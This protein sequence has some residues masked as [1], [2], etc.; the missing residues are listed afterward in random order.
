MNGMGE[1]KDNRLSP[2]STI[3]TDPSPKS[4]DHPESPTSPSH[5]L[6]PIPQTL[7]PKSSVVSSN[8]SNNGLRGPRSII[9]LD[10]DSMPL[11]LFPRRPFNLSGPLRR[12]SS[13]IS[14][15]ARSPHAST[16]TSTY[17]TATDTSMF[18]A[19]TAQSTFATTTSRASTEFYSVDGDDEQGRQSGEYGPFVGNG[20]NDKVGINQNDPRTINSIAAAATT[21]NNIGGDNNNNNN[22][23][24][25]VTN[26][27]SI[28][29]TDTGIDNSYQNNDIYDVVDENRRLVSARPSRDDMDRSIDPN[30]TNTNSTRDETHQTQVNSRSS[31]N[32]P[33]EHGAAPTNTVNASNDD[34]REAGHEDQDLVETPGDRRNKKWWKTKHGWKVFI[35][36]RDKHELFTNW[37]KFVLIVLLGQLL[38]LCITSTTVLTNELAFN[39]NISVPTTQSFLVYVLLALFYVPF[40]LIRLG[41]K[42]M[43]VNFKRRWYW[44]IILAAVDVE[45]NFFVVKAYNYTSLLSCMLLDAWTLP[46]VVVL[47]FFLMKIRFHWSQ[48]LGVIVC[49]V[50]LGLLIKSDMDSGKNNKAKDAV[51]GDIFMLIGATCYGVSNTL[52]EY[53]VRQRPQYETI[54]W[55]GLFGTIINGVQLAILERNELKMIPWSGPVVGYILGFDFTMFLLYSLTPFL[56]RLS[57]AA[58]YN[59]SILTSDFYGLIFGIYLFGYKIFPLY[60][61]SYVI[62]IVGIIIYNVRPYKP[63]TNLAQLPGWREKKGNSDSPA[64]TSENSETVVQEQRPESSPSNTSSI[65]RFN[66]HDND[67]DNLGN[68]V[69]G[70]AAL[71]SQPHTDTKAGVVTQQ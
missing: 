40:T 3:I 36:G 12:N 61:G 58:F 45:G 6:L 69:K 46:V 65:G 8:S 63:P 33:H 21:T 11:P 66:S 29:K 13:S 44:Y 67:R 62:V 35:F 64:P 60:A 55:L 43:W 15:N 17:S 41:P 52:E 70:S 57:S 16:R 39:Y 26:P 48:Y 31:L 25:G 2:K 14:S 37:K 5:P 19:R 10:E 7:S 28:E 47:T 38:S 54:A 9:G 30:N 22:N 1:E 34:T 59:L 50:G 18:S 24:N 49:L 4:Q 20:S 71:E 23:N 32:Q 51:K 27:R 56:F 53:I 42:A 68:S